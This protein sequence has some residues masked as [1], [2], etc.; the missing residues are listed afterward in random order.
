MQISI[1]TLKNNN[2]IFIYFFY[3]ALSYKCQIQDINL[4]VGHLFK[5]INFKRPITMETSATVVGAPLCG[6][7]LAGRCTSW[8]PLCCTF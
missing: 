5:K 4:P 3:V 7:H 8:F 2:T 6:R 1:K